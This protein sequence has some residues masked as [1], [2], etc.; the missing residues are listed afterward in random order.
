MA[1]LE[2]WQNASGQQQGGGKVEDIVFGRA[3]SWSMLNRFSFSSQAASVGAKIVHPS[4]RMPPAAPAP[5]PCP[6][7][8]TAE[9]SAWDRGP[10]ALSAKRRTVG[11]Q[12]QYQMSMQR[13]ATNDDWRRGLRKNCSNPD[14]KR[15][16]RGGGR[17][18]RVDRSLVCTTA[19]APRRTHQQSSCLRSHRRWPW[20]R[21]RR[22]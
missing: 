1:N 2:E 7:L 18:G 3:C 16:R 4:S 5:P 11:G 14:S 15:R 10:A 6:A 13:M 22:G 17:R 21:R 8:V 20:R 19:R 12:K 9:D